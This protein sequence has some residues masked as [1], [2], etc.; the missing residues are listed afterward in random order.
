MSDQNPYESSQSGT[1]E[2]EVKPSS[3][4]WSIGIVFVA[5]GIGGVFGLA[6]G[7]ALGSLLPGYY[8]SVFSGGD[9]PNFDPLA[10]GI[11]Q[12]ITQGVVFGAVVGLAVVALFYWRQRLNRPSSSD[13]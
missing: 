2:S 7:A 4:L 1:A 10:V 12:G 5:S 6:I 9:S 13:Q 8:R 3:M 11:G